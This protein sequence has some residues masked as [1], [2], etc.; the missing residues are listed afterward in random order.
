MQREK[1]NLMTPAVL[2][3]AY[4][5]QC[6]DS[7]PPADTAW[8]LAK[9]VSQHVPDSSAKIPQQ[10]QW[11]QQPN[12]QDN[13]LPN[14]ISHNVVP[15]ASIIQRQQ[16]HIQKQALPQI[17][18]PRMLPAKLATNTPCAHPSPL[19]VVCARGRDAWNHPGNKN[20]RGIVKQ[21][22]LKYSQASSKMERSDI[23]SQ[24]VLDLR[25]V[26]CCF[27]KHDAKSGLWKDVGDALARNKVG[28]L[29]RNSLSEQYRSSAQAKMCRRRHGSAQLHQSL[30][31]ILH[32][33]PEV[34]HIINQLSQ[35]VN[36]QNEMMDEEASRIFNKANSQL[37]ASLK[38]DTAL[39]VRFH[40][41]ATPS[42]SSSAMAAE[43]WDCGESLFEPDGES[44][45]M[46][47]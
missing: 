21:N 42:S 20:L 24:I 13:L 34:S 8:L 35:V 25:A 16:Q 41:A 1:G 29:L 40:L 9:I 33:N 12:Q 38:K 23:V 37:L 2:V 47:P 22:G 28:H 7:V 45:Q 11:F 32:S 5:A 6:L 14:A 15:T 39:V 19:D 43:W 30:S 18:R 27:L 44:N 36:D 4:R 26:G 31:K 10:K 17:S 46:V 3:G